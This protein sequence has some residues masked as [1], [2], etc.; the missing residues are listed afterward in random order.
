MG[1]QGVEAL[2]IY[3]SVHMTKFVLGIPYGE[4]LKIQKGESLVGGLVPPFFGPP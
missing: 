2:N 3:T 4:L 1:Q